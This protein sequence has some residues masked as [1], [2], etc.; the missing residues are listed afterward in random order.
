MRDD[1]GEAGRD[2][3]LIMHIKECG[4]CC[5]DCAESLMDF[6]MA[7]YLHFK[8][9]ILLEYSGDFGR[10]ETYGKQDSIGDL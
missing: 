9:N 6:L 4:L 5:K 10:G 1:I 3:F 8:E 2:Q 7:K